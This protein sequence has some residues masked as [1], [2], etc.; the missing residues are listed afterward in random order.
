MPNTEITGKIEKKQETSKPEGR[1]K[2]AI[3]EKLVWIAT[4]NK[5]FKI[6]KSAC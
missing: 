2:G 5:D 6:E 3:N 4:S 1:C